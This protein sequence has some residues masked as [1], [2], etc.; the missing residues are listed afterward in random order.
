[1]TLPILACHLQITLEGAICPASRSR[2]VLFAR[3]HIVDAIFAV[4]NG[5]RLHGGSGQNTKLSRNISHHLVR[6]KRDFF[7][8]QE[9]G[10]FDAL[11]RQYLRSFI[12]AI[13]LV[14]YFYDVLDSFDPLFQDSKDPN[15]CAYTPSHT[16][17]C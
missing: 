17:S 4:D 9:Y 10:I 6:L 2:S 8:P 15:K 13:Y 16:R 3:D 5:K 12:F 11:Q 14:G 7:L 1:M